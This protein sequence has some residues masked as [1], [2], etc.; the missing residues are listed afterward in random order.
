M[1]LIYLLLLGVTRFLFSLKIGRQI[2]Q[3]SQPEQA[4]T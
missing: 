2:E 4:K 1:N 3:L